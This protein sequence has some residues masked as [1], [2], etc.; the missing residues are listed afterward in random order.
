M[1]FSKM[2]TMK[3]PKT[4]FRRPFVFGGFVDRFVNVWQEVTRPKTDGGRLGWLNG[5]T[6]QDRDLDCKF[7]I[8][9]GRVQLLYLGPPV[10]PVG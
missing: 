6:V 10:L 8:P 3:K 9:A 5:R 4:S 2:M 7:R 1:R